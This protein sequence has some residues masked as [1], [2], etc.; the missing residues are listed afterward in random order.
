MNDSPSPISRHGKTF[1]YFCLGFSLVMVFLVWK[2]FIETILL[3]LI[4]AVVFFPLYRRLLVLLRNRGSLASL[5]TCLILI[6][7]VIL[8]LAV[9]TV[10]L[11]QEATYVY[12]S[13]SA[14]L[15]QGSTIMP[16]SG[17]LAKGVE[18]LQRYLPGLGYS[19]GAMESQAVEIVKLFVNF[20]MRH[21]TSV[22]GNVT[23]MILSFFLLIFTLFYFLRDGSVWLADLLDIIPM[24]EGQK[25]QIV[26]KFKEVSMS[27]VVGILLTAVA[28]GVVAGIGFAVAG[29][30][31]V[32]WGTSVAFASLIPVVGSALVWV[33]AGVVLITTGALK[34]GMFIL[35]WGVLVISSLD[36]FLRPYLMRGGT[37]VS[38]VWILF[39]ILGGLQ[40]FGFTGILIGPLILSMAITLVAIYRD[41]YAH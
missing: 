6:L 7:L 37:Q 16:R 34:G 32:L 40:L 39:S 18:L 29:I 9:L 33:P 31:P 27:T 21:S 8:P 4:C 35:V 20:I 5:L 3:S 10:F 14:K 38:P 15:Q 2:P 13:I 11:A 1:F 17:V 19:P 22:I 25:R 12:S 23:G 24:P 26:A 30:S 28:Q 36:N 41:E